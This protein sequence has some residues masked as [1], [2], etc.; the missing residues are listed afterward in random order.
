LGGCKH[1]LDRAERAEQVLQEV[2]HRLSSGR[3]P[4][5]PKL[6]ERARSAGLLPK[7]GQ[8]ARAEPLQ[9]GNSEAAE[10]Q[11]ASA[12]ADNSRDVEEFFDERTTNRPTDDDRAR[13]HHH[14]AGGVAM[15]TPPP[16]SA[17]IAPLL[18][19]SVHKICSGQAR[20]FALQSA[21][22]SSSAEARLAR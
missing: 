2:G 7:R 13:A 17:I 22:L 1:R 21:S 4:P 14:R 6:S 18:P 15:Q 9:A 20:S 10:Q 12:T 3:A 16:M 11:E 5:P 19:G 8:S